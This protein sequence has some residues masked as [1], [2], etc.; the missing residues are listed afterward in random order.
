MY[1]YIYHQDVIPIGFL[2]KKCIFISV[3]FFNDRLYT[4]VSATTM[5]ATI[6]STIRF[7]FGISRLVFFFFYLIILVVLV[8]A[9]VFLPIIFFVN[10]LGSHAARA[11]VVVVGGGKTSWQ[12]GC[13]RRPLF[14]SGSLTFLTLLSFSHAHA[15]YAF[16]TRSLSHRRGLAVF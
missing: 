12:T 6:Y 10:W 8:A 4:P 3:F 15:R 9:K 16:L 5:P 7:D 13:R 2:K 1:V 14:R 11:L